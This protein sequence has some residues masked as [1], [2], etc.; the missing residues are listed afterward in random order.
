[1]SAVSNS[2]PL[3]YL[4]TLGDFE[5]LRLL[6]GTITIPEAVYREVAIDGRGQP[7]GSDV[8]KA[9]GHWMLTES[10]RDQHRAISLMEA[11]GIHAGESEAIVLAQERGL[12]VILL[13]D[14]RAVSCAKAARLKVV[15]TPAIYATA[16][17]M[18]LIDSVRDK[19]DH[20]RQARFFL[21]DQDYRSILRMVGE[22]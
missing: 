21:K 1:M 18:G 8:L 4:G 3:I 14:Q 10:I 17:E 5:L 15:R 9:S 22:L 20:L 16:K 7:G 12:D 6:F 13:D 19:L 2:S 11:Q